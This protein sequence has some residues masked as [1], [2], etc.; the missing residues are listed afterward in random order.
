MLYRPE[1][2][3]VPVS[4]KAFIDRQY[5]GITDSEPVMI[6]VDL[7]SDGQNE[8]LL[9]V[10]QEHGLTYSQ[11]YYMTENGWKSGN[12]N[13]SGFWRGQ[14]ALHER[15]KNG[16]IEIVEPRFKHLEIDGML[17]QPSTNN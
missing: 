16:E 17:L 11:F 4:L 1:P 9:L 7:D 12:V 3:E 8:F 6:R 14:K 15:I 2:F 10:L 5:F 13:Q